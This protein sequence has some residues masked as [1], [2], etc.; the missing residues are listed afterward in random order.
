MDKANEFSESKLKN[1]C[2]FWTENE[3]NSILL[4][5][6]NVDNRKGHKLREYLIQIPKDVEDDD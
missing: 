3:A 1:L 6:K 5:N 2:I 4:V